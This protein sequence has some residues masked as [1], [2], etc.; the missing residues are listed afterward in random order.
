MEE[1]KD[2]AIKY[3]LGLWF[4][5]ICLS[6]FWCHFYFLDKI[7]AFSIEF[8]LPEIYLN[9]KLGLRKFSGP[10]SN[11]YKNKIEAVIIFHS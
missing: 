3:S 7:I 2:K 6:V 10:H 4:P 5:G 1:N 11:T 8:T 9:L